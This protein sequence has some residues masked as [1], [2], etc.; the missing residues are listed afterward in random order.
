[1]CSDCHRKTSQHNL[2]NNQN[3]N[4]HLSATLTKVLL[5]EVMDVCML[6][7]QDVC[8]CDQ[9]SPKTVAAPNIITD[10]PQW[11]SQVKRRT[12]LYECSSNHVHLIPQVLELSG[13]LATQEDPCVR[14]TSLSLLI[15]PIDR[16]S[17]TLR[18][19]NSTEQ[20]QNCFRPQT[21]WLSQT[22]YL[23]QKYQEQLF[24]YKNI[25]YWSVT[26]IFFTSLNLCSIWRTQAGKCAEDR[27]NIYTVLWDWT[28]LKLS[29][30]SVF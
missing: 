16:P 17:H 9:M 4:H 19:L 5:D 25:K 15:N 12:C 21:L 24:K 30:S 10:V 23:N 29:N 1:M 28:I 2:F 13:C 11:K 8:V 18:G 26:Q 6:N 7:T 27:D 14:V 3:T 20:S 22:E